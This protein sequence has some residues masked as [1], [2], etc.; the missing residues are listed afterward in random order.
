[1]TKRVQIFAYIFCG[2]SGRLMGK[3]KFKCIVPACK[4]TYIAGAVN[5]LNFFAFPSSDIEKKRWIE[6]INSFSPTEISA[7]FTT[8]HIC[9]NHFSNNCFKSTQ[10]KYVVP[11]LFSGDY[12][13]VDNVNIFFGLPIWEI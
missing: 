11:T 10:H 8:G 4:S 13:N 6:A 12:E 5:N 3:M 1:V 9:Q 7:D 2:I